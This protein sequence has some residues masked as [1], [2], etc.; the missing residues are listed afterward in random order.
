MSKTIWRVAYNQNPDGRY[1]SVLVSGATVDEAIVRVRE[2]RDILE[3][4]SISK[5]DEEIL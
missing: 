1:K 4:I 2:S 5:Q 3:I